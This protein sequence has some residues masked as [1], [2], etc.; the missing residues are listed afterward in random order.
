[1]D[2][3]TLK[4]LVSYDKDTGLFFRILDGSAIGCVN[5]KGYTSFRLLGK[6]WLAHRLAWLYIYGSLPSLGLDHINGERSDNRIV[7][8][9]EAN[10]SQNAQNERPKFK[11]NKHGFAGVTSFRSKFVA[12]IKLNGTK[13][14][15]GIY[16]TAIDASNAYKKAKKELH[17]FSI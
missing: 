6:N 12:R 11:V 4:E 10:H 9:R 13:I 17:P 7:N 16:E 8:L 2:Q 5:T 14:Y 3:K 1:M 15:I